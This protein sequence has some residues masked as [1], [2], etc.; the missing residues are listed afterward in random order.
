MDDG[1]VTALCIAD[2]RRGWLPGVMG[3][4]GAPPSHSAVMGL[5]PWQ[6][7]SNS[8]ANVTVGLE[9]EEGAGFD[10]GRE[11]T[12]DLSTLPER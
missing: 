6:P 12:G 11:V 1:Y 8:L 4:G 2:P 10:I 9:G 5:L 7:Q 3:G